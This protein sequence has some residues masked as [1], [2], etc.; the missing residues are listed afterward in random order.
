M[1]I[2]KFQCQGFNSP[3]FLGYEHFRKLIYLTADWKFT[4]KQI[5]E[6]GPRVIDIERIFNMKQ[7]MTKADD[8]LPRRYF[9]DPAPLKIAKGHH[10]DRK[11]F[12]KVLD[13]Y[14]KLHNWDNDGKLRPQRVK[15]LEAIA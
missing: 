9:D 14:Y 15:E 11:E 13:R 1:G 12:A 10:I 6:V 3:H 5:R 8:T 4:D 2:C 7:G